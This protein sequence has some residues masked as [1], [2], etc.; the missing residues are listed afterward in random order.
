MTIVEKLSVLMKERN[1]KKSHVAKGAGLSYSTY[2]SIFKRGYENLELN[3]LKR[4]A[5]Y[6]DVTMEYLA[7]D[8]AEDR[9]AGKV[10]SIAELSKEEHEY[11]LLFRQLPK[12]EQCKIIGR[13]EAIIEQAAGKD[14]E[15]RA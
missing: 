7:N 4:L 9:H 1:L 8:E 13:M 12:G 5:N 15:K 14:N 10:I 3:T 11:I 6:F 2:N